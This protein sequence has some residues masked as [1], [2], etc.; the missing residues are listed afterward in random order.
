MRKVLSV[1]MFLLLAGSLA[2][3][4][5]TAIVIADGGL[6]LRGT[7]GSG[8][9]PLLL[10]AKGS[11]VQVLDDDFHYAPG[12]PNQYLH[13]ARVRA[14]GKTGFA[15]LCFLRPGAGVRLYDNSRSYKDGYP[16]ILLLRPDGKGY[17]LINM[18]EGFDRREGTWSR[19]PGQI[20][21]KDSS[22]KEYLLQEAPDSTLKF[23]SPS[24]GCCPN[25]GDIFAAW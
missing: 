18:C 10:L 14:Q 8:G 22:G 2:A 15:A 20:V 4:G 9:A 21:F 23:M 7:A 6:W 24:A 13:W 17:L 19:K 11:T 16:A 25:E 3:A 12:A 1:S 5:F